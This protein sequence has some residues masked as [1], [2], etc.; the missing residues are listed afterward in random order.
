MSILEFEQRAGVPSAGVEV[1]FAT[2]IDRLVGA[3]VEPVGLEDLVGL[4]KQAMA[5]IGAIGAILVYLGAGGA[6][7]A[8]HTVGAS[9]DMVSALGPLAVSEQVPILVAVR[10]GEPVWVPSLA[11]LHARFP[12]FAANVMRGQAL[13]SLPLMATD[14][15]VIGGL[16]LTLAEPRSFSDTERSFVLTVAAI[17][18]SAL[19]RSARLR[20]QLG[21]DRYPGAALFD[22]LSDAVLVHDDTVDRI[23]YANPASELLFRNSVGSVLEMPGADLRGRVLGRP[24]VKKNPEQLFTGQRAYELEFLRFDGVPRLFDVTIS[25][26]NAVGQRALVLVDTTDRPFG[27]GSVSRHPQTIEANE[28]LERERHDHE[29]HDRAIQAVFATSM[30]LAALSQAVP[31]HLADRVESLIVQLDALVADLGDR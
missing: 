30:S 19:P 23:V 10:S 25:S 20:P 6:V 26:P 18:A 24:V 15:R 16:G 21:I 11:A 2:R 12:E 28:Q 31:A 13:V 14:G 17:V 1:P 5:G 29:T 7:E 4:A 22:T 3:L 9:T 8:V 27:G